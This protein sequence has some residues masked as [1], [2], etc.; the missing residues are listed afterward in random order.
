MQTSIEITIEY[1]LSQ[2]MDLYGVWSIEELGMTLESLGRFVIVS[3]SSAQS[4]QYGVRYQDRI[5]SVNGISCTN[6]SPGSI[7]SLIQ[8]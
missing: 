4:E 2:G 8:R 7:V 3:Q 5:I 1:P 6:K